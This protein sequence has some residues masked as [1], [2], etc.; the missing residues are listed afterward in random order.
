MK[1]ILF[2]LL[3]FASCAHAQSSGLFAF[4]NAV[5]RGQWK[6]KQQ[7]ATLKELGTTA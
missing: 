3:A 6:P 4:D 2:A 1:E 7:A 5:G